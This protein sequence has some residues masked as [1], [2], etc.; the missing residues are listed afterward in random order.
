LYLQKADQ[1]NCNIKQK[2]TH[3]KH[4]TT[5]GEEMPCNTDKTDKGEASFNGVQAKAGFARSQYHWRQE[6]EGR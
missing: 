3:M 4:A 1:K 2:A 6:L 5:T